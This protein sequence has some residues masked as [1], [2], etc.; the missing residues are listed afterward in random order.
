M[1]KKY[2]RRL[3]SFFCFTIIISPLFSQIKQSHEVA[4]GFLQLKDEFGLGLVFNGAHLE[5][6]YGL[7]W[8]IGDHEILY[9]PD[10][11]L[12]GGFNRGMAAIHIHVAPINATWTMPIFERNGHT[13]RGGANFATNY[14]Y[15]VD[16]LHDGP[17]FWKTE[18]G[19]SPVINYSYQWNNK[20]IN[21]G[22]QNSLLG[23]TSRRQDYDPYFWS[24]TWKDFV[25]YPNKGLKLG[26]FNRYNH[27]RVSVGF[28][29]NTSGKHSFGYEFDYLGYFYGNQYHRVNHNLI[30][31]L[32]L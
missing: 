27:T 10:F 5:Y 18:I 6:R 16:N 1:R 30:W 24:F 32:S 4:L 7:K 23:F 2:L 21:A 25:L 8:K 9:Q 14:N 13:V 28:V 15:Q 20:S 22:L 11:G 17:V 31:K 29:P 12:G 19:L 3:L 26:S